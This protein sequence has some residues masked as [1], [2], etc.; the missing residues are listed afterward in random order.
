VNHPL[1]R[2]L[3]P[4]FE[5]TIFINDQ[6]RSGVIDEGGDQAHPG[7]PTEG[8]DQARRGLLAKGG[9]IDKIFAGRIENSRKIATDAVMSFDF[10][11]SAIPVR[12]EQRQTAAIK[13]Y[14]WR[15]QGTKPY[16]PSHI[17]WHKCNRECSVGTT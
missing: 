7:L 13:D 17:H 12:H 1:F 4:H 8:G 3:T 14:P 11:T 2:L 6:A 16:L 10:A 9:A 5:G 15:L